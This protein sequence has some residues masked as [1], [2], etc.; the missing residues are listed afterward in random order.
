MLL[1]PVMRKFAR[2]IIFSTLTPFLA[3]TAAEAFHTH[4][5]VQT[6]RNCSICQV[7]HETP[8]L[9]HS[10]VVQPPVLAANP[11][12]FP[13]FVHPHV[14]LVFVPFSRSPPSF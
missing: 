5:A 6:E 10:H 3:L 2:L 13:D 14:Q 7:A 4:T 1:E 12:W 8:A 9:T 11:A